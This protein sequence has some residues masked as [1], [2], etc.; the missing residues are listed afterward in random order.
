MRKVT[1]C[2][3]F[4]GQAEQAAAYYV[5]LLPDSQ[6]DRVLRSPADTPSGTAGMVLA[7]EFTLAG[8]KFSGLNGGPQFPFTEAVSFQ[9]ACGDQAEVDRLW[10]ALSEGG[11]PGQCGW[12]K[13]R[14]GLSWQIV[15]T[16]LS[17]L[18]AD[19]DPGRSHRAM[20]AML[21]MTKLNIAELERAADGAKS[22]NT[23]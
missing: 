2:L 15:P 20:Q 1:P 5:S 16:R 14:W 12:L 22:T 21:K 18:L 23:H 3:W 10:T 9:I 17:Q 19:P 11:S 6:I 13:D 4:D 8:H 7:V